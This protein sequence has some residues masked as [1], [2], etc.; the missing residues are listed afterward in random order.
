MEENKQP[1]EEISEQEN[2]DVKE[3]ETSQEKAQEEN[4]ETKTENM[5]QDKEMQKSSDD[6]LVQKKV[7]CS[8]AYLFGI[9]FFLP[10]IVYPNDEFAKFHANQAL[11]V[12][13]T[14]FIGELIFGILSA[15][16]GFVAVLSIIFS[17]L[18][19]VF[20]LI[21]LVACILAILGVVREEKYELPIIGKFKLIK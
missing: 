18:C 5:S 14:V 4:N 11:V 10:L 3:A 9:L 15:V 8:L 2:K 17:I 13:L 6:E 19:G 12:L 20:G 21:M 7:I 16:L 1:E